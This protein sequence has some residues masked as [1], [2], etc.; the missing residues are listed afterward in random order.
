MASSKKFFY[1]KNCKISWIGDSW[2]TQGDLITS[3]CEVCYAP[4]PECSYRVHNLATNAW[5]KATGPKTEAGKARVALNPWKDGTKCRKGKHHILAPAKFD[6]YPWCTEC[7]DR[8]DC[9]NKL[10]KYCPR[11]FETTLRFVQAYK[12]GD[13]NALKEDA[14]IANAQVSKVFAMM[15]SSIMQK[16]V[17]MKTVQVDK[18]GNE[19]VTWE[20]NQLVK[21]LPQ[22]MSTLGFT[23]DQQVMTPK[24]VEQKEA[25]QSFVKPESPEKQSEA[26]EIRKKTAADL[27]RLRELMEQQQG[28]TGGNE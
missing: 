21:E 5:H 6:K 9:E 1:C 25:L 11:D 22:Y 19:L 16:G 7:P 27:A 20:K 14:A 18:N 10:I 12:D 24:A 28:K 26:M 17:M 23:A 4:A 8:D 15:I 13:V 3:I 2:L